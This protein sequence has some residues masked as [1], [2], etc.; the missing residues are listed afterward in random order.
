MVLQTLERDGIFAVSFGVP[1]HVD[2]N[3]TVFS[4]KTCTFGGGVKES[5]LWLTEPNVAYVK[6]KK[7]TTYKR[8]W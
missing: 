4:L 6:N 3:V 2:T 8:V 7:K 1:T 5:F